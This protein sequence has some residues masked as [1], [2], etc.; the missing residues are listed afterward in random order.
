MRTE[1][2]GNK[3]GARPSD[4]LLVIKTLVDSYAKNG[5]KLYACFV[6]FRKA[7]DSVWRTGLFYKLIKYGMNKSIIKLIKSM[8]ENTSISLKMNGGLTRPFRTHK[9]VRQGCILSPRLFNYFINDIP[10]I[11]DSLCEP[12]MLGSEKLSCLMYA[13][14]L[15]ILSES[16]SGLQNCLNRLHDYTKKWRLD[17]NLKK[18]KIMSFQN[19]GRTS[20]TKFFL[21]SQIV[22][23][24]K[25]YKYL[26]TFITNTGNFGMNENN[27]KRKGLR[28]SYLIAKNI[29]MCSK[30][31]TSIKIFEKVVEPIL[32]YNSEVAQAYMPKTWDFQKFQRGV[33]EVGSEIN[34][35]L[36]GFLRQTL[37]VIKKTPNFA[38]LGETGKYP[39]AV[40]IFIQIIKFW[41][42]LCTSQ[43]PLLVAARKVNTD[44][45][46]VGR[47]NWLKIVDYLQQVVGVKLNPG[48]D[49]KV[50]TKQ[51]R[52]F[53]ES[54][55]SLF[56]KGWHEKLGSHENNKLDFFYKYKR[57]FRF[58]KYLD[59]IPRH[60]R[61]HTTRLRTSSHNLP[62]ERLR[63]S[64]NKPERAD[65]KCDVCSL[66]A[67]GDERHLLLVCNNTRLSDMRVKFI[68]NIK[69][70]TPQF[71][72]FTDEGIMDY[73]L[74]MQDENLQLH[75]AKYI[76]E[77]SII[78]KEEKEENRVYVPTITRSGRL[79]RRPDRL[80][81]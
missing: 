53:G 4:H 74:T 36:L 9:G 59:R 12:V 49:D 77:I 54:I 81:L 15:V 2:I 1:Q 80:D 42:R 47:Q 14:D 51:I 19:G 63:Y 62:V 16:E 25:S 29:G 75:T 67:V 3:K 21:D 71:R 38:I 46:V 56:E 28:A 55:R 45:N 8:Y 76:K 66:E 17:V 52:G 78:Y 24:T 73:C 40:N 70:S 39:I 37:G 20:E 35:V 13:D 6:D 65:R 61:L 10:E 44:L 32:M 11:F 18:T 27:L 50:N 31:S 33:W 34:R 7:Y 22:E 68:D 58:E 30:P 72:H 43:N 60:I 5:K 26:G 57:V 23:R 79:V 69:G 48:G 64:K 41:F